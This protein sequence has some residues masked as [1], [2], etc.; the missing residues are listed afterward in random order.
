MS[1]KF[2]RFSLD[3]LTIRGTTHGCGCCSDTV[4]V[5]LSDID[6]HISKLEADIAEARRVR[7]VIM[8]LDDVAIKMKEQM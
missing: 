1:G 5:S 4:D 2:T 3:G 6:E 8:Q 7:A